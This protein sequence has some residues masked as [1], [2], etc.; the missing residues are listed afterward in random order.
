MKSK[1]K[2][3]YDIMLIT[4]NFLC[5][6]TVLLICNHLDNTLKI[7]YTHSILQIYGISHKVL[8]RMTPHAFNSLDKLILLLDLPKLTL[9]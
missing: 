3:F 2:F 5:T 6:S 8:S 9:S 1:R 4:I 7:N